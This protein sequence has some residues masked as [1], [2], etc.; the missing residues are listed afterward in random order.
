MMV[1]QNFLSLSL[2]LRLNK[3]ERLLL[4]CFFLSGVN[5]FE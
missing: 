2:T 1:L 3:L 4:K 5:F